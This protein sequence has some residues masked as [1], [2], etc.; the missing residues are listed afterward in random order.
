MCP[1]RSKQ[2]HI[3]CASTAGNY[4]ACSGILRIA[5]QNPISTM[6]TAA[7]AAA[8]ARRHK[9]DSAESLMKDTGS[10]RSDTAHLS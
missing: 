9:F 5:D 3:Q 10:H 2:G 8:A 1:A 4:S 6:T 7:A